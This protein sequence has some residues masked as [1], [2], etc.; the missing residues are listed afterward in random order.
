MPTGV[1]ETP[2][3][4]RAMVAR[5]LLMLTEIIE[6]SVSLSLSLSLSL[7]DLVSLAVGMATPCVS[8]KGSCTCMEAGM[9]KMAPSLTWNAMIPVSLDSSLK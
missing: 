5:N 8:I 9:M 7:S 2:G 1:H 3:A 4:Q 6:Q